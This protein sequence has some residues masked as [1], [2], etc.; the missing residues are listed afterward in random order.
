MK[1]RDVLFPNQRMMR[2]PAANAV[3]GINDVVEIND[4]TE[5]VADAA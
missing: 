5:T 4:A 3:A 2:K 1:M